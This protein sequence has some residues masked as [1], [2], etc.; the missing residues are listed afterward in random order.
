MVRVTALAAMI[1][2]LIWMGYIFKIFL[3]E[4]YTLVHIIMPTNIVFLLTPLFLQSTKAIEKAWFKYYVIFGFVLVIFILNVVLPKHAIIGWAIALILACHYYSQKM[5]WIVFGVTLPAMMLGIYLGMFLGEYDPNL[6]TPGLIRYDEAGVAYLYQPST[7]AERYELLKELLAMGENR[8]FAAFI[9]YFVPRA[10]ILTVVALACHFLDRRTYALLRAESES[11]IQKESIQTELRIASQIQ[12]SSL[13]RPFAITDE[14]EIL[15]ELLPA[16]EVGGDLYD[17]VQLDDHHVAVLIGDVSGKG[18]PSAMWMMKTVTCFENLLRP[19]KKP[20]EIL[21]EVNEVLSKHNESSTFVTCFLAI[22][23]TKTGVL[24]Y[25]N[26]GHNPPLIKRGGRGFYLPVAHGTVLG[27]GK[28]AH[29]EDETIKL[30]K[31]DILVLYTD[32]ITE[33]RNKAGEFFGTKRLLSFFSKPDFTSLVH[34]RHELLDEIFGFMGG[35]DQAD[36]LTYL[37]L[38][39]QGDRILIRELEMDATLEGTNKILDFTKTCLTDSHLSGKPEKEILLVVDEIYSNVA[40][41]AYGNDVG[42]MYFRYQF[43]FAKKEIVLTFV[44][45]G[46]DFNMIAASFSEETLNPANAQDKT[47]GGLGMLLVRNAV[48]HTSYKRFADKNVLTLRKK[49]D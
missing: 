10:A 34:L 25:A 36:D 41:Y 37:L 33:A 1:L 28:F 21:A 48:D 35:A 14:A 12:S 27:C 23:D 6:L 44:D 4:N 38:Q 3:L 39:Y 8:Y 11:R 17:Y 26:A 29:Y 22:L 31:E 45:K 20:S 7:P 19:G 5:G 18:T 30:S 15:A 16:K 24:T 9:Y 32:G 2:A 40:K 49:I 47:P 43:N 46:V 42:W 13:P